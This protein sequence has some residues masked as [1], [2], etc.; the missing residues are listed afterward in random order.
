MPFDLGLWAAVQ[1]FHLIASPTLSQMLVSNTS[2][3]ST[4]YRGSQK[5]KNRPTGERKG[6]L[7]PDWTHNTDAGGYKSDPFA[8]SWE[9]TEA[10]QLFERAVPHGNVRRRFATALGIAFEAKPTADGSWH[11]Y[12]VPWET[13]PAE[14]LQTWIENGEVTRSQIKRHWRKDQDDLR[15]A[16]E[17]DTP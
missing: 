15:W 1:R 16:I 9:K 11:G 12:P 6:T 2:K 17:G 5:H 14:I 4:L 10:H 13:V 7:C 3:P 8:H